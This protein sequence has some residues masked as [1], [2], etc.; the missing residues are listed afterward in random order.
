MPSPHI[1]LALLITR[2]TRPL[3]TPAACRQG[4]VDHPVADARRDP[5]PVLPCR[6]GVG[7]EPVDPS[8]GVT[9]DTRRRMSPS[10]PA[11]RAAYGA[12]TG[13]TV[14]RG[15]PRYISRQVLVAR[16]VLR[17]G[18]R[19]AI[20]EQ[21][22]FQHCFGDE[23]FQASVFLAEI[24]DLGRHRRA[25]GVVYNAFLPGFEKF[26]TDWISSAR[27]WRRQRGASVLK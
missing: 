3:R 7:C 5:I 10:A 2:N 11:A 26:R 24:R 20:S 14:R 23:L 1:R 25:R 6:R 9:G 4:R 15:E 17:G 18:S 19:H 16:L 27:S 21:P 8:V 13:P 22:I 12:P